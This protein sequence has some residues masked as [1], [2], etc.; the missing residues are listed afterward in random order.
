[1]TRGLG[2]RA[3]KIIERI[4]PTNQRYICV[5]GTEFDV[6]AST[7]PMWH[8]LHCKKCEACRNA[9][10]QGSRK[11]VNPISLETQYIDV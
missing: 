1:M 5:D 3:Q 8:K 7:F 10:L 9:P 4:P 2:S 11:M 6:R